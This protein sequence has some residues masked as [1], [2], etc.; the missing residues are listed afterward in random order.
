VLAKA[1]VFNHGMGIGLWYGIDRNMINVI[2]ERHRHQCQEGSGE[3]VGPPKAGNDKRGLRA[4]SV[5]LEGPFWTFGGVGLPAASR[6]WK[7]WDP[8]GAEGTKGVQQS[9]CSCLRTTSQSRSQHHTFHPLKRH[10]LT[11]ASLTRCTL[12]SYS[13]DAARG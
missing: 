4:K 13:L 6:T 3:Q 2:Q 9:T 10:I 1:W 5:G 7:R 12:A 8:R 11:L